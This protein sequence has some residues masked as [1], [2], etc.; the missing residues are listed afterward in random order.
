[1]GVKRHSSHGK[2]FLSWLKVLVDL[3]IGLRWRYY[4]PFSTRMKL[5]FEVGDF[6]EHHP[7]ARAGFGFD[8]EHGFVVQEQRLEGGGQQVSKHN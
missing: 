2:Q 8:V 5:V 1:M 4:P 6:V 3:I 7:S